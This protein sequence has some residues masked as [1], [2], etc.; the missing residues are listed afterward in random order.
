[1]RRAQ[2]ASF[3]R[4]CKLCLAT[5]F[6]LG[7]CAS[8]PGP[9]T[10]VVPSVAAASSDSKLEAVVLNVGN[11]LD[12][13][14]T[15]ATHF[16][17]DLEPL[18]QILVAEFAGQRG[19]LELAAHH[20]VAAAIQ[21]HDLEVAKRATRISVFASN[22]ASALAA[23]KIWVEQA[24]TD[25][26]ARQIL[27]AMHIRAGDA[28]AA[29]THL[30]Y[31]LDAQTDGADRQFGVI[32]NLLSREEDKLTALD[33]MQ[34]LMSRHSG[35]DALMA[36]ALLAI[37][38]EEIEH[39]A[40]AM[41]RVL[42]SG[43]LNSN[44]AVAYVA[45][46]QKQDKT[47]LAFKWLEQV[48]AKNSDD[49]SLR[50]LYARLLADSGRYEQARVQFS[51]VSTAIP[52]NS[53]VVYALGLLNLQG[54]RIEVAHANFSR[55]LELGER[56]DDAN[57]HLAQ[58]AE[59]REEVTE[60]LALYRAVKPGV[61]YFQ[62]QLR[63]ALTLSLQDEVADA[64][65]Q[66][67]SIVARDEEQQLQIVRVEGEILTQ[68]DRLEDAMAVYD[69]ALIDIYD[70]E[71]LYTRAMLAE[72]MGRLDV[73]EADL[74]AIIEREPD[75]SQA[76]NALGYTLADH[77]ERYQEAYEFI[78]RA[79]ELNAEDFYILDSMGWVLYR[80][81]RFGEA[82]E[83]LNR[84]REIKN[85]PE[86]AAHLGEVLWVM[87]DKD[88]ARDIWGSALQSQPDDKRLLDV[89]ERLAQ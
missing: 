73:L 65:V 25:I 72:K 67:R 8:A 61:N 19:R 47:L 7:G 28:N 9:T 40:A 74:H 79:L 50:L 45:F 49:T 14:V 18:F 27:A 33:V 34:R 71:L 23:A 16:E 30:E 22:N 83:F 70:M 85:D 21:L 5:V 53:D 20:Y 87:G 66:L 56:G 84:A 10:T 42:E 86:V 39:A 82:V 62:A 41:A 29:I 4:L 24:P 81:G 63:T 68:H 26:E 75:N 1:M 17:T 80:L 35:D 54:N 13:P 15:K 89:I 2:S 59:S 48:I 51:I 37:R 55:L 58:I 77:T 44:I 69:A 52:D 57:F 46:L 76:L 78:K 32:T 3:T 88:A 31:V 64:R 60:A 12:R 43:T 36:Y 38:A 6:L 11:L